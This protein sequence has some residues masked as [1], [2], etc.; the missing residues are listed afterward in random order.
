[1]SPVASFPGGCGILGD[2]GNSASV[3][4]GIMMVAIVAAAARLRDLC[5][6]LLVVYV[7]AQGFGGVVGVDIVC[8]VGHY[9]DIV[10]GGGVAVLWVA[11]CVV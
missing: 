6:V 5:G 9:G 4:D 10:D 7:V 1:M 11:G 2:V 8:G 3:G